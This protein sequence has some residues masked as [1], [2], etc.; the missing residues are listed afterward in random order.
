MKQ[1]T[2]AVPAYNAQNYLEKCIQSM[3][4][5]ECEDRLEVIVINDGSTDQTGEIA[6]RYV[7][8][9][10]HIFRVIH[11][12]NG[13]HGSGINAASAQA[14]GRYF[15]VVDAD[16][17]VDPAG[18]SRL[19]DVLSTTTVDALINSF[20]TFDINSKKL[21]LQRTACLRSNAKISL[22]QVMECYDVL[23]PCCSLH[24]LTYNTRVYRDAAIQLSEKVFYEDNEYAIL[25][26][27]RIQTVMILDFPV[28]VYRIGDM[29][30][31]VSVRNQAAK[32]GDKEAVI[33]NLLNKETLF[34]KQGAS[35]L[36][37]KR[38]MTAL[39]TGYYVAA[40]F[41]VT[42]RKTGRHIAEKMRGR[43]FPYAHFRGL[44]P[45][46]ALLRALNYLHLP[47]QLYQLLVNNHLLRTIFRMTVNK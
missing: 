46:Y 5:E 31:S 10:P 42:P 36:Y 45:V 21:L 13:G 17:W 26:F 16:D 47:I 32:I 40:L 37:Y 34:D 2:I 35:F 20:C 7:K 4:L 6:T 15:K 18:L 1:L 11:K 29:E 28:Y 19:L 38:R 14:Q 44:S 9:H 41:M 3:I 25:P 33:V 39:I 30:Q 24:G 8:R 43:L 23:A 22:D 27:S 12:E